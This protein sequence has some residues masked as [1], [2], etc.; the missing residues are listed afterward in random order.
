MLSRHLRLFGRERQ[1]LRL[2]E[3]GDHERVFIVLARPAD[4]RNAVNV[5]DDVR[6][7]IG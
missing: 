4:V 1:G 5:Y 7:L 2:V 6:S 3:I